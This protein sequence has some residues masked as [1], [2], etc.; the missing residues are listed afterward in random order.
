MTNHASRCNDAVAPDLRIMQDSCIHADEHVVPDA[1]AVEDGSVAYD[2]A[3]AYGDVANGGGGG[4]RMDH[5]IVFNSRRVADS[6]EAEVASDHGSGPY[7]RFLP[8]LHVA[9]DISGLT[10]EG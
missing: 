7:G 3:D 1:A 4:S 10:D 6:N 5:C 8:D 2:D 9:Y